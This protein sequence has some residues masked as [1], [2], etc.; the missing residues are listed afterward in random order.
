MFFR[1][2][3]TE[4]NQF[5]YATFWVAVGLLLFMVIGQVWWLRKALL[6]LEVKRVLPVEYGT[7]SSLSMIGSL[8]SVAA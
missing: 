8:R 2:L 6:R 1:S 4:D 5:C 3:E 7:Q